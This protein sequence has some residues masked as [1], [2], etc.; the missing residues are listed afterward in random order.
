MT[1]HHMTRAWLEARRAGDG[2][3]AAAGPHVPEGMS[4]ETSEGSTDHITD[5]IADHITGRI[6]DHITDHITDQVAGNITG[7][8][9]SPPSRRT[10]PAPPAPASEPTAVALATAWP[11][12]DGLSPAAPRAP[13]PAGSQRVRRASVP[14][15]G[16]LAAPPER[17]REVVGDRGATPEQRR[18]MWGQSMDTVAIEDQTPAPKHRRVAAPGSPR[19]T[20]ELAAIGM[21]ELLPTDFSH[22]VQ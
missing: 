1:S 17:G 7:N 9:P 18:A 10:H 22:G 19:A 2:L 16:V 4:S 20:A 6:P 15:D 5:H 21:S 8:T 12:R 13:R 14:M 11:R 3:A